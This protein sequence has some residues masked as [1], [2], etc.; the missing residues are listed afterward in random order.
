LGCLSFFSV[1]LPSHPQSIILRL[2]AADMTLKLLDAYPKR[3]VSDV[4]HT[5]IHLS[6]LKSLEELGDTELEQVIDQA[7][8]VN[9]P[10]V[11][12]EP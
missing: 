9:S 6:L 7:V 10:E 4:R 5:N 2:R 1:Y 11:P 3:R 12:Q 8:K